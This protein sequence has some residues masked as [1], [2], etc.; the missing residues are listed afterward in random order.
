M[1]S[2]LK[3]RVGR[4]KV[5]YSMYV[6]KTLMCEFVGGEMELVDVLRNLANEVEKELEDSACEGVN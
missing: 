3:R 4:S 5:E 2:V 1:I 6:N